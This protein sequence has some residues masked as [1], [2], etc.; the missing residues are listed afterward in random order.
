[1]AEEKSK[2]YCRSCK[3]NTNHFARHNDSYYVDEEEIILRY[4]LRIECCGCGTRSYK[5]YDINTMDEAKEKFNIK[6]LPESAGW[7]L[8]E[9][10]SLLKRLPEELQKTYKEVIDNYNRENE[11]AC[12]GMIRVLIEGLG[13]VE[14]IKD[15]LITKGTKEYKINYVLITEEL[16]KRGFVTKNIKEIL[17]KLRFIGNDALHGLERPSREELRLAIQIVENIL[18][19]F[20]VIQ[21]VYSELMDIRQVRKTEQ[22]LN[23]RR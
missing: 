6:I 20:Y 4:S 17:E 22:E 1:M 16:F 8:E 21:H 5:E 11:L 18:E 19:N 9:K 10:I 15:D 13:V 12:S 3:Q 7:H 2:E 14:G 23:K